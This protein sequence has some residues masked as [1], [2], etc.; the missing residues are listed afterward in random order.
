MAKDEQKEQPKEQKKEQKQTTED[1]KVGSGAGEFL[2]GTRE[3][4][5][6]VV[7]PSR[8]QLISESLAVLLMV[9]LSA[10]TVYFV[11]NLFNWAAGQ[12]FR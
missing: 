4:L 5:D 12:V 2:K 8:Q 10:T 1:K 7:W 3:E 11:D 9:T 6:K